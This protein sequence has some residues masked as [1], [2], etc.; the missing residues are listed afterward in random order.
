MV[1]HLLTVTASLCGSYVASVRPTVNRN[2]ERGIGV[3]EVLFLVPID[4][5]RNPTFHNE[6][7]NLPKQF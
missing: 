3:T 1:Y 5:R 7:S 4:I 6:F 2:E